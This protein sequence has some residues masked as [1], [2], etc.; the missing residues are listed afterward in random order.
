MVRP[1]EGSRLKAE[2][3]PVHKRDQSLPIKIRSHLVPKLSD[4]EIHMAFANTS[5]AIA[6]EILLANAIEHWELVYFG[7]LCYRP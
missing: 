7:S 5:V 3:C 6:A 1:A 2:G 4:S